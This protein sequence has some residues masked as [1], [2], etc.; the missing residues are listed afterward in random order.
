MGAVAGTADKSTQESI[1]K[2]L[3]MMTFIELY[4]TQKNFS[5]PKQGSNP[6]PSDRWSEGCEEIFLSKNSS[7][8]IINNI[9]V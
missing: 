7:M 1:K 6:Q 3:F 5:V 4:F 9:Y 8:N 2:G